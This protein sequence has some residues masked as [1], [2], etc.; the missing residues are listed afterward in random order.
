MAIQHQPRT[1]AA[2][3]DDDDDQEPTVDLTRDEDD[4]EAAERR[5]RAAS[6]SHRP[7]QRPA[8]RESGDDDEELDQEGLAFAI[9]ELTSER[10][11]DKLKADQRKVDQK[12]AQHDRRLGD[13]EEAHDELTAEVAK[14]EA[15]AEAKAAGA[16]PVTA[17][18]APAAAS[19]AAGAR[20]I[21][22]V[23]PDLGKGHNDKE[24]HLPDDPNGPKQPRGGWRSLW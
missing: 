4:D 21:A 1:R 2:R 16:V 11:V 23:E 22:I 7:A 19:P 5:P 8:R 3:S 15:K 24:D 20:E 9:A 13:L 6:V 18:G 14:I 10:T 12:L 17:N